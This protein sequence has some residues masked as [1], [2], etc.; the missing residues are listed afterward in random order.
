[1]PTQ[2]RMANG[3]LALVA[4]RRRTRGENRQ[5]KPV[6]YECRSGMV[7]TYPSFR[8]KYGYIQI[9]ARIPYGFGLWPA[10]W[11]A[12]ANLKWPPEIDIM[13]HWASSPRVD[14]FF[15]PV[16][17]T[18]FFGRAHPGNMSFGWHSFSLL[19]SP[20]KLVWFIDGHEELTVAQDIPDIPMYLI[21]N[22]ADKQVLANQ[23]C[24]GSMLIRSVKVW[25]QH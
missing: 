10:L 1:M 9:V 6:T 24:D 7:T 2:D 12:A 18:Q 21:A 3:A 19:W 23:G 5:A 13:E 20:S 25:Q 15:H 4:Q 16:G 11:L 8:F 14:Q 17:H 22:V